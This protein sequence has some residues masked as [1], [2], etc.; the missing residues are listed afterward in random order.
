M[1]FL[2]LDTPYSNVFVKRLLSA[3]DVPTFIMNLSVI[4]NLPQ[5]TAHIIRASGSRKC[6][7]PDVPLHVRAVRNT[8]VWVMYIYSHMPNDMLHSG[9][10]SSD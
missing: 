5:L 4:T 9:T 2:V 3:G 8:C 10:S 6:M 1:H 7:Q